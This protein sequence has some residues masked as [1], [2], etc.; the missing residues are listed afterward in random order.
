M[1]M[2]SLIVTKIKDCITASKPNKIC[3]ENNSVPSNLLEDCYIRPSPST[4][5]R[6]ATHPLFSSV[7][8]TEVMVASGMAR[9]KTLKSI[10]G[11]S[12]R[13]MIS[14]SSWMLV[15]VCTFWG[16]LWHLTCSLV[17][18]DKSWVKMMQMLKCSCY[19][20]IDCS[21]FQLFFPAK[22]WVCMSFL[23]PKC[24]HAPNH[25]VLTSYNGAS[26]YCLANIDDAPRGLA[27]KFPTIGTENRW[28]QGTFQR[29]TSSILANR[30]KSP[31]K[32]K[33]L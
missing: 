24:R 22:D 2:T 29:L 15:Q 18:Y 10:Q 6:P 3:P 19:L 32:I 26:C 17:K 21:N 33:S 12:P 20:I 1:D 11:K 16:W 25:Q 14:C 13:G 31:G 7:A 28:A 4:P 8:R 23:L 27:A 30:P 5:I 9:L